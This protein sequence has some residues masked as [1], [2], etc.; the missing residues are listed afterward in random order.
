M[1]YESLYVGIFDALYVYFQRHDA[2]TI[3]PFKSEKY[4]AWKTRWQKIKDETVRYR[5]N[6]K[7][8]ERR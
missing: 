4:I 3:D 2:S 7:L 5:R 8:L 1:F 6:H